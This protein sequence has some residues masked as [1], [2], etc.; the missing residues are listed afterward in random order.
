M[1]AAGKQIAAAAAAAVCWDLPVE[2]WERII[3]LLDGDNCALKSLSVVSKQFLSITNG[4]KLSLKVTDQTILFFSCVYQRFP[5]LTSLSLNLS[6]ETDDFD[7]L[8][9]Q[10]STFP[11]LS[12]IKSLYISN[13]NTSFP[14]NGLQ[15]LSKNMTN[16]TSFTCSGIRYINSEDIFFTTSC[17]RLLE[18]LDL[19]Y[20]G[21][22]LSLLP[23][24]RKIN[25]SGY[26]LH[27]D[28]YGFLQKVTVIDGLIS[29]W[30]RLLDDNLDDDYDGSSW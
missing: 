16:L 3:K 19:S 1:P 2:L 28:G 10:I 24:L 29:T 15:A 11:N 17:F 7:A 14:T 8:L 13:P 27:K 22:P 12:N 30:R 21:G 23:K 20:F 5:N 4:I 26:H 18:E 6:S 9:V 25:L